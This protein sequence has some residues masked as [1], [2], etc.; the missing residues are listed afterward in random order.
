MNL[1]D[2]FEQLAKLLTQLPSLGPRQA[3]RISF[4]LKNRGEEFLDHLIAALKSLRD[5]AVCAQ[6]Y[7]PHTNK[8]ARCSVCADSSRDHRTIAIVEKET[9]LLSIENTGKYRGVYFIVGESAPSGAL[10][11]TQK[12]RLTTLKQRI[13]REG[14]AAEIIIA[15]SPTS[16]GKFTASLLAHELAGYAEKITKPALGL[17]SG[18][19]IE[20][21]D[22]ETLGSALE[23]RH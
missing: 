1:P 12:S 11:K 14:K 23:Q 7:M 6:C 21:A 18:G 13:Q 5:T 2:P 17:P 4:F 8:G 15:F 3:I 10:S 19:E 22:D 16:E 20:F 9:D